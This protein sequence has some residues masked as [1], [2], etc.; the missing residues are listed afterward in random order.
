MQTRVGSLPAAA[1][2]PQD[3]LHEE[4]KAPKILPST[5]CRDGQSNGPRAPLH[6]DPFRVHGCRTTEDHQAGLLGKCIVVPSVLLNQWYEECMRKLC[7]EIT[8]S[9]ARAGLQSEPMPT[10]PM[11]RGRRCSCSCSTSQA[12]SPSAGPWG[13][14]QPSEHREDHLTGQA[15]LNR[16]PSCSR[17][18]TRYH[19]SPSAWWPSR[20]RSPFPSPTWPHP[21]NKLLSCSLEGLH[22]QLRSHKFWSR[23]WQDTPTPTVEKQRKKQV[24]LDVDEE[25]GDDPTLPLDLTLFLV[26]GMAEEQ[27]DTPS[28]QT[29]MPVD[30]SRPPPN[31]GLQ[32]HSAYMGGAWPKAPLNPLLLNWDP[33]QDQKGNWIWWTTP[34]NGFWCWWTGLETIPSGGRK[35]ELVGGF[36]WLHGKIHHEGVLHWC[37]V[38]ALCLMAGGC[39]QA[40]P[41][42]DFGLVGC[43]IL[44]QWAVSPGF[45]TSYQ[46]LWW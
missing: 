21:A 23:A 41:T 7:H 28:S 5:T 20:C 46:G 27:D 34:A 31:E 33:D 24:R 38:L 37:Q 40:V 18:R 43:P 32:C 3:C 44:A 17:D 25:M 11:A 42:W 19:Q 16:Q 6:L 2:A 35:L 29:P 22:L 8:K 13:W 12:H 9:N 15:G 45:Q 1:S 10:K 26:E 14:R 36:P 39:T 30:S 4:E